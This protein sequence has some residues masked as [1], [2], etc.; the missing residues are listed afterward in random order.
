MHTFKECYLQYSEK[1]SSYIIY[2]D[3]LEP[4]PRWDFLD[5]DDPEI[6]AIQEKAYASVT[7]QITGTIEIIRENGDWDESWES[8]VE[9]ILARAQGN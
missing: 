8:D 1:T 6:T 2:S 4:F 3:V 5:T 7:Q 9:T